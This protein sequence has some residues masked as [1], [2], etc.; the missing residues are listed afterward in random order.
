[1]ISKILSSCY[2]KWKDYMKL[3]SL[4]VSVKASVTK[5]CL[6]LCEPMDCSLPG[7]SVHG[8]L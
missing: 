2:R 6:A 3:L 4:E 8:I 5:S 7:S 1:M